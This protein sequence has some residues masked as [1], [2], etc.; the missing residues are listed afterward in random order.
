MLSPN[1][2]DAVT[3]IIQSSLL[4]KRMV[5]SGLLRTSTMDRRLICNDYSLMSSSVSL[6]HVLKE[7][8]GSHFLRR[9][10]GPTGNRLHSSAIVF[11]GV[12]VV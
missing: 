4:R 12:R 8:H 2:D 11:R 6:N 5:Q 1:L 7:Q 9:K 3:E 10:Y